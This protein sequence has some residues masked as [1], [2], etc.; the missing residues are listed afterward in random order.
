MISKAASAM[1]PDLP[2]LYVRDLRK[3]HNNRESILEIF[4]RA[5]LLAPCLLVFD[6]LDGF[7]THDNRTVFLN[8]LDGFK[9]NEGLFVIASSNHPDKID[10]ALLR[11][12][13]RFDRVFH[14]GLPSLEERRE[15]SRRLLSRS[16]LAARLAPDFDVEKIAEIVAQKS[17]GFTPAYLKEAFTSA[18]LLRAHEGASVLDEHFEAALFAQIEELKKHLKRSKNPVVMTEMRASDEA[19]GLRRASE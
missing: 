2:F 1:L 18:A 9:S 15:Y 4:K 8:E 12:P 10:E 6:D 7:L 13:S 14:I 3:D 5:R 16:H 19:I 17:D 11:R